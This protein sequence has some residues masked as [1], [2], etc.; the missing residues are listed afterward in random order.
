MAKSFAALSKK[1]KVL[2]DYAAGKVDYNFEF[3]R[4]RNGGPEPLGSTS[5]RSCLNPETGDVVVF[6]Y[7]FDITERKLQE[8]LLDR[9]V[10]LDYEYIME[11]DVPQDSY[12]LISF[13]ENRQDAVSGKARFRRKS[14]Q[15]RS[16]L[17][18]LRQEANI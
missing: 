9:I 13:D 17:W 12:W 16:G 11:I 3:L 2:A 5:F 7:T 8:M 6:F 18:M 14:G 1:E 4:K 10:E 15:S